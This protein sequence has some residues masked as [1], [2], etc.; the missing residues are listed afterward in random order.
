MSSP[1]R[2]TQ[3]R[4]IELNEVAVSVGAPITTGSVY[5]VAPAVFGCEYDPSP[6]EFVARTLATTTS[7]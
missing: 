6:K 5:M 2:A 7:P 1:V 4:E 3:A